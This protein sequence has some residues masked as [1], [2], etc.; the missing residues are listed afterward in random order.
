MMPRVIGGGRLGKNVHRDAEG[1]QQDNGDIQPQLL[2]LPHRLPVFSQQEIIT[3]KIHAEKS[4]KYGGHRLQIGGISGH[5]VCLDAEA[6]G[7][8]CAKRGAQRVKKR[9]FPC[10]QEQ[11]IERRQ[12]NID[13]IQNF[14]R[15]PHL[16]YNFADAGT[17][18]FRPH[19]MQSEALVLA[20]QR[21]N[22]QHED[23]DP[24]SSD[25]VGE[26]SPEEAASGHSLNIIQNRSA[27]RGKA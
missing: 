4:H 7:S 26:A 2:I 9:H 19:Q 22:R 27:R 3:R 16:R 18:R 24:H 10:R 13:E 25:P 14:G 6:S 21:D 20:T 1:A 23:Q 8:G 17:R 11:Y 15:L 12:S 5:T